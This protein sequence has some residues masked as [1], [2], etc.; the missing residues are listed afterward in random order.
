MTYY[1]FFLISIPILVIFISIRSWFLQRN[2]MP[3]EL[4]IM[5]LKDENNGRF[6]Q[7]VITYENALSE[8]NKTRF[9]TSLKNKIIEKLRILHTN[10]DYKNSLRFIR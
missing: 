8:V 1:S 3:V 10:I 2:N 5:A 6:E 4:Y 7:A 9:H